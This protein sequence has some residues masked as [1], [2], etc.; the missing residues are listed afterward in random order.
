MKIEYDLSQNNNS[1]SFKEL[2]DSEFDQ[3]RILF[4]TIIQYSKFDNHKEI[5]EKL[6][7][8]EVIKHISK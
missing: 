4:L 7:I 8:K 3:I 2:T 5:C 1:I 6:S